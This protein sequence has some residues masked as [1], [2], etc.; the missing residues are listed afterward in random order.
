MVSCH[1][2]I[3]AVSLLLFPFGCFISFSYLTFV[4]NTF[5]TILDKSDEYGHACCVPDFRGKTF[6]FAPLSMM[7]AVGLS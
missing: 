5:N 2:H 1:P 7:L 6:S 4:A 3:V